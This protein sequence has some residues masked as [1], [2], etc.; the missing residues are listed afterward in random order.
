[1]AKFP[2]A[3]PPRVLDRNTNEY[4]DGET[5]FLGCTVWRELAEHAAESLTKG[6][7][8][9]VVGRL[10]LSRWE[11]EAGEKRSTYGL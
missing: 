9:V 3:S 7:W 2:I 11:T 5:L 10:R 6:M 1:M 4:K 8:V